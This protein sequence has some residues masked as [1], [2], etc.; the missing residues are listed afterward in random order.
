MNLLI[1]SMVTLVIARN[2]ILFLAAWE[3]MSLASFFLVLFDGDR[4]ETRHAA[5]VY[6]I[7]SHL[8][9][10]PLFALFCSCRPRRLCSS[11]PSPPMPRAAGLASACF[12]LALVG[13]GTK[14]GFWPLHVWL[15]EAH[16]A[17]PSHVSAVM[18]GVMIKMGIYGLLRVLLSSGRR[19]PGGAG[20]ARASARCPG[21]WR[22]ASRWRSTISSGC[23]PITA[24]RTS[25]S[26]PWASASAFSGRRTAT[27]ARVRSA[28]RGR[29]CTCSTTAFSRACCSRG[30]AVSCTARARATSTRSA[31]C[32]AHAGDRPHVPGRL[33]GHRRPAA[34]QRLCQRVAHLLGAFRAAVQP[35]A[36]GAGWALAVI[37]A[38]ALIGGLAAA[39]FVKAYGIVFL[40]EPRSDAA[41]HAHESGLSHAAG[42]GWVPPCAFCSECGPPGARDGRGRGPATCGPRCRSRHGAGSAQW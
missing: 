23:S 38:L 33:G 32:P 28:T 13:F 37:P 42:H 5:L 11:R 9:T 29:C 34:A 10:L 14:A 16:P 15:P 35:P 24:S 26:S 19:R 22:A 20:A 17:A 31:A 25:A 21:W 41:R 40:G 12:V 18:S 36:A 8:G 6:L 7:A 4:A 3:V 1:A 2:G 39:C 30:P 27:P